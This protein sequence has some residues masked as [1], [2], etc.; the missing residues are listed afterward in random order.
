MHTTQILQTLKSAGLN[1]YEAKCYLALFERDTLTVPEVSKL[2]GIPRPNAY[3][4][5]ENLLSKGM[6]V[7]RPGN[8]KRYG[9]SDP[10]VLREKALLEVSKGTEIELE[11]LK[12]K[13]KEILEKA[14]AT[15]E[16]IDDLA[17]ELEPRYEKS[18]LE[19]SPLDYIEI[20]KDPLQIHRRVVRLLSEA[21]EEILAFTKPPFTKPPFRRPRKML[22]ERAEPE[23]KAL[24]R[25]VRVRNIYEIPRDKEEIEWRFEDIDEAVKAGEEA[26][27]MKKLPMKMVIV[28]R[29]VVILALADP[30][31][32]RTSLTTQ[33]VEHRD[34]ADGLRTLFEALWQQAQ[35]YHIL[36]G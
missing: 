35:D 8:T 4:A 11:N 32:K 26:R 13:E 20:L 24:R 5:L 28:D 21:K 23:K 6:C 2:A 34:L 3:E 30:V 7:A 17:S 12:N 36:E 25:G 10:A 33:I 16:N 18:T 19:V 22:E 15:K 27:V 31:S 1:T 14:N 9:A 29:K